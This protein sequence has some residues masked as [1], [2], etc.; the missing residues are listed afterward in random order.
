ML[1]W[2]KIG[3][4]TVMHQLRERNQNRTGCTEGK[5]KQI[6]SFFISCIDFSHKRSPLSVSLSETRKIYN[7]NSFLHGID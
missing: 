7:H 1:N 3:F 2:G 4:H 5:K 6:D